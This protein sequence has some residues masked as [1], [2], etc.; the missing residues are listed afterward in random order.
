MVDPQDVLIDK[1]LEEYVTNAQLTELNET[2]A[3]TDN[4]VNIFEKTKS[5]PVCSIRCVALKSG[6]ACPMMKLPESYDNWHSTPAHNV[7]IFYSNLPKRLECNGE[8]SAFVET[9]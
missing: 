4:I 7:F 6:N 3:I 1:K 9:S 8:R 2:L 5:S